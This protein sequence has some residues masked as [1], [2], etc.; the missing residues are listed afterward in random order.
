L[1]ELKL[2]DWAILTGF[3]APLILRLLD[4]SADWVWSSET[5]APPEYISQPFGTVV[6]ITVSAKAEL[7]TE[8]MPP[9]TGSNFTSLNHTVAPFPAHSKSK[10]IHAS[11]TLALSDADHVNVKSL[12]S[13]LD[14]VGSGNQ[15]CAGA[16]GLNSTFGFALLALALKLK[17]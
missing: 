3:P 15:N 13:K 7:G 16:Q 6:S 5:V 9:P 1:A 4:P 17:I 12:Q 14:C 10:A 11:F 2:N 8:L